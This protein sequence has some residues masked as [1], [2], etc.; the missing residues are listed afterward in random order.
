[1]KF[2]YYLALLGGVLSSDNQVDIQVKAMNEDWSSKSYETGK[3]HALR[4]KFEPKQLSLSGFE[5]GAM[6]ANN[7]FA[8][9]N[10]KISGVGILNGAGPCITRHSSDD[11]C[12]GS[13]SSKSTSG[14]KDK[15]VYVYSGKSKDTMA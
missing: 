1:M 12:V 7:I 8:L 10:S 11:E 5:D 14:Y 15:P 6:V 4:V 3:W 9:H 2:L 13:A